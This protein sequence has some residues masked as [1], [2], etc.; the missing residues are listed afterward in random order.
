MGGP[1]SA[2]C[3]SGPARSDTPQTSPG[4][5]PRSQTSAVDCEPL[6]LAGPSAE[7]SGRTGPLPAGRCAWGGVMETDRLNSEITVKQNI[8]KRSY[9]L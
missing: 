3:D 7:H 6:G 5:G 8:L 4:S 9:T 1:V 2:G